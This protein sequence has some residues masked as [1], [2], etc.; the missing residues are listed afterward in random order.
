MSEIVSNY[1]DDL[2]RIFNQTKVTDIDGKEL[3]L[4]DALIKSAEM[5]M[6]ANS[7]GNK[8]I[9][10]GNGGSAA[11]SSHK[12]L[13]YWFTGKI[14]GIS[15]SDHV[16]LTCVT[17]DFGYQNVFVKQIEMFADKGDILFAISSSGN[18]EN[19]I[20]AVE[21][22]RRRGCLV[23]TFSGFKE[24]NRLRNLGDLNFYTPVQHFNKVESLHL[25]LCDCILEIIV[26]HRNNF[27]INNEHNKENKINHYMDKEPSKNLSLNS[28]FLNNNQPQSAKNILVAL[29]RDGTIIYDDDGYFGKEDNWRNKIKFYN[30]VVEAITILNSFANVIVNTNQI[31]VAR[32]FYGPERV[33]EINHTLNVILKNQGAMVDGWYFSP[34]VEKSW[35]EKNG[36]DLN[37]SWVLESFPETRKPQIGMLKLAAID[38]KKDLFSYKKIFAIG[39]SIDDLK[40]A[41]NAGGIGIF[42]KNGKNNHLLDQI[43]P[44]ELSNPGRIFYV[45]NLVSAAE[46]IKSLSI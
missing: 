35:A 19:I 30:G 18:S 6:K 24:I 39:D 9:F 31:G 38:S 15:F 37:S 8:M 3:N 10:I 20:L 36:L 1:I 41:L 26:E 40:M 29:D 14:R 44:L 21:A 4:S 34:Y 2:H 17:N 32:G 16:N 43:K 45:D 11:V 22:A 28:Y 33:K 46:I 12:A 27:L 13:D 23:F 42:F 7:L 5:V 25:L